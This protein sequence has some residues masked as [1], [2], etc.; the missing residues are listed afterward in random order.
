MN[1]KYIWDNLAPVQKA[2]LGRKEKYK[3]ENHFGRGMHR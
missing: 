3:R 1:A 2:E